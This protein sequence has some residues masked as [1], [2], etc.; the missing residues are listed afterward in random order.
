MALLTANCYYCPC[1]AKCIDMI[2]SDDTEINCEYAGHMKKWV[3]ETIEKLSEIT[4]L[5][6]ADADTIRELVYFTGRDKTN[7]CEIF[8]PVVK[9]TSC[10]KRY[11]CTCSE[12][13]NCKKNDYDMYEAD[14]SSKWL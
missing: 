6:V 1:F 5:S 3:E 11:G 14:M 9:C 4:I 2:F 8:T 12:E 10:L 13:Y 7:I